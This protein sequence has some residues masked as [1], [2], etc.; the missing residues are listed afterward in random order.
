MK[1]KPWKVKYVCQKKTS[2]WQG[3]WLQKCKHSKYG[4]AIKLDG[5]NMGFPGAHSNREYVICDYSF[6]QLMRII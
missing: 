5:A 6:S 3:D 1:S 2:C 4:P